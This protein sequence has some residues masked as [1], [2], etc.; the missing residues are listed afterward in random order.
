MVS[1]SELANFAKTNGFTEDTLQTASYSRYMN[2]ITIEDIFY[3]E[4]ILGKNAE[5]YLTGVSRD[6]DGNVSKAAYAINYDKATEWINVAP[7]SGYSTYKAY[8]DAYDAGKITA[9]SFKVDSSS[10][11]CANAIIDTEPFRF[12][13]TYVKV[14]DEVGEEGQE[15]TLSFPPAKSGAVRTVIVIRPIS[16]KKPIENFVYEG[17]VSFEDIPAEYRE[18]HTDTSNQGTLSNFARNNAGSIPVATTLHEGAIAYVDNTSYYI[19]N[20]NPMLNLEGSYFV[21]PH[22]R[23]DKNVNS[24]P[25]LWMRAYHSGIKSI[26]SVYYPNFPNTPQPWYSFDLN[27][28]SLL[29][30]VTSG[31]KPKFLDD[32]WQ[33]LDIDGYAF[34][35]TDSDEY[36]HV[37]VKQVNV[38]QGTSVRISMKTP[39]TGQ[40]TDGNYYLFIKPIEK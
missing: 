7:I 6:S 12:K 34:V 33:K 17:P 35:V 11:T 4:Y 26:S 27:R 30:I 28:S 14:F 39:A 40:T 38:E 3:N 19:T 21:P 24:G 16:P 8:R 32:T 22:R 15:V 23:T 20:I 31:S 13:Y 25:Y 29:Y 37:Y 5:D 9:E 10:P 1:A 18:G 36:K 2:T